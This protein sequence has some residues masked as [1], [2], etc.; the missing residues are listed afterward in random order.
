MLIRSQGLIGFIDGF[1][2]RNLYMRGERD[3]NVE[4][5]KLEEADNKLI[6]RLNLPHPVRADEAKLSLASRISAGISEFLG[7][8]G[9]SAASV[10]FVI[11]LLGVAS[12]LRWSETGQL[13]CNTP[14]MI[15]E[16]FLLLVLIQA[17]N[18]SSAARGKEF[19]GIL[20]RRVIL[21]YAVNNVEYVPYEEEAPSKPRLSI[22]PSRLSMIPGRS[23]I[24][25]NRISR[26]FGGEGGI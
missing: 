14:T 4:F 10:I 17:H 21:N 11:L 7:T 20:K 12:I 19:S 6:D 9:V 1:I 24:V 15:I 13:L 23:S 22:L 8:K 5:R 18:I 26:M 25:P 16:G 2:L 3:A